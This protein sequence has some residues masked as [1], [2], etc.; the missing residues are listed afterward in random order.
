MALIT[1][2]INR[3]VSK[4]DQLD[5]LQRAPSK[6][7]SAPSPAPPHAGLGHRRSRTASSM[8]Y[9]VRSLDARRVARPIIPDGSKTTRQHLSASLADSS[10]PH[11]RP[12]LLSAVRH[13]G[14][15]DAGPG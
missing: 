9:A 10:A 13:E 6:T 4:H 1:K 12:M 2:M 8:L 15:D 3:G 11:D 14:N 7:R 5:H